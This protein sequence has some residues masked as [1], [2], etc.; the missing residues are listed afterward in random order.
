MIK[1]IR[2]LRRLTQIK[3]LIKSKIS[4]TSGQAQIKGLAGENARCRFE[5]DRGKNTSMVFNM[6]SESYQDS[7]KLIGIGWF[8]NYYPQITQISADYIKGLD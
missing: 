3:Y 4:R 5:A 2:R 8:G 6:A 1:I 7:I